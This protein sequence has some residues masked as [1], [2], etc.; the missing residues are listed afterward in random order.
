MGVLELA[1]G[2]LR[3]FCAKSWPQKMPIPADAVKNFIQQTLNGLS[4]L[5]EIGIMHRDIKPSNLLV[6]D[7]VEEGA[8]VI[9]KITDYGL[10]RTKTKDK[11]LSRDVITLWYRPPEL[12]LGSDHYTEAVDVWSTGCILAE[13]LRREPLICTDSEF[14]TLMKIYSIFGS[15]KRGDEL[16]FLPYYNEEHPNFKET[17]DTC[18]VLPRRGHGHFLELIRSLCAMEPSKRASA[19]AA[20]HHRALMAPGLAATPGASQ[21]GKVPRRPM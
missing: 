13:L 1:Q 20:L 3:S 4:H 5:H 18:Q 8:P 12:L 10:S 15:P 9:I 19:R 14:T 16:T 17:V 6:F 21:F 2:D 7:A 11:R